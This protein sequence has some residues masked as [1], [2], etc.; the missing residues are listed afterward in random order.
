[1][2]NFSVIGRDCTQEQREDYFEWD[3][4]MGERNITC[5]EIKGTWPKLDAVVGGQISI[6]IYV[7]TLFYKHLLTNIYFFL[8]F[9]FIA[10]KN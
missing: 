5:M 4:A 7:L 2:L 1:M 8:R 3:K 6:D 9:N 10:L